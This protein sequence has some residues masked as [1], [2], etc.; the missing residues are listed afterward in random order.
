MGVGAIAHSLGVGVFRVRDE[1]AAL[2]RLSGFSDMVVL[3]SKSPWGGNRFLTRF[4]S[5]RR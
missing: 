3:V 1:P 2:C 5:L 4:G